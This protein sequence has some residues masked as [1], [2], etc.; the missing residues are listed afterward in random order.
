MTA[1]IEKY[2]HYLIPV[3]LVVLV[4]CGWSALKE[5][6]ARILAEQ[7]V[8]QSNARI[9]VLEKEKQDIVKAGEAAKATLRAKAKQVQTT[10]QAI[11]EMP[12]VSDLPLHARP[13]PDA[14]SQVAVDAVP[15]YQQLNTCKQT[16]IDLGTCT[17]LRG[18]DAAEIQ[19]LRGQIDVLKGKKTFWRRISKVA[20][21]TGCAAGGAL[22]GGLT[23]QANAAAVG[24]GAGAVVCQM[25]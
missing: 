2:F 25:F 19:E 22:V 17:Q 4:V 18:K 9:A 24:A 15:L 6:D 23:K 3:A 8:Q 14:P 21:V 5:H 20:K 11:T 16:G 1:F 13:F 7:A 12:N 10:E